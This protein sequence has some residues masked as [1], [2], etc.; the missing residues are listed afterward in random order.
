MFSFAFL[1]VSFY[2]DSADRQFASNEINIAP[3]LLKQTNN[4]CENIPLKTIYRY[5]QKNLGALVTITS[6][7]IALWYSEARKKNWVKT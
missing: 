2:Q 3:K 7:S 1:P 6:Q 5:V 4:T